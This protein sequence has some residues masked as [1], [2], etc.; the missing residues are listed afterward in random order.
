[1]N[2]ESSTTSHRAAR[3]VLVGSIA[4]LLLA[5][6]SDGGRLN[7]QNTYVGK[8]GGVEIDEQI[9]DPSLERHFVLVGLLTERRDGRLHV[10]FDLKNTTTSELP[11]EWSIEWMDA[12][13][14]RIDTQPHWRPALVGGNGVVPVQETAPVPEA[15]TFKLHVRRSSPVR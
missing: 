9:G 2:L 12:R 15:A 5:C 14:F 10:Q 13:G 11:V 4:S 3:Q 8:E 7:P 6:A 1:M